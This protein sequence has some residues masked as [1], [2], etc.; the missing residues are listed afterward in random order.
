MSILS[1]GSYMAADLNAV[2]SYD[3]TTTCKIG[4]RV[5]TVIVGD[6]SQTEEDAMGGPQMI[7][8]QQIHFRRT[9]LSTIEN[10]TIVTLTDQ[11]TALR[12]IVVSNTT[13]ADGNELIVYVRAA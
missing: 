6:N 7:D 3:F 9:D 10:G 13:S 12:K 11:G 5:Y 4:S 1:M 8:T 2:F